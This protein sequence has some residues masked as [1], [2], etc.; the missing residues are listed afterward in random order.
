MKLF[1]K[2]TKT[3]NNQTEDT[4]QAFWEEYASTEEKIYK[5][6]LTDTTQIPSGSVKEFAEKYETTTLLVIGFLDGIQTSISETLNLKDFTEES[7]FT[8][9]IDFE[10]L[11]FNML[12]AQADYLF[13]LP[14]WDA[15]LGKE[16]ME[17]VAKAYKKSKTV[18]K[19]KV[20]GRN[21]PCPCGSGKKYKKC[22]GMNK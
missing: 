13:S 5:D 9:T 10:K 7:T 17:E 2:W 18:I 14:E 16:K 21:E 6:I 1:T 22:C 20:P 11:F 12:A 3:L 8:L 19:E 15:V 4:F